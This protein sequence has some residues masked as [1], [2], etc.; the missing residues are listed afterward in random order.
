MR[1]LV[2][3]NEVQNFGSEALFTKLLDDYQKT[4]DASFKSDIRLALPNTTNP[5]LIQQ[6]V[7]NFENAAVIKPQDLRAWYRGLLNNEAG[8]QA[9]WDWI[10]N[11]WQW[12][13][14]TVGG[15]M[16]FATFITVTANIFHTPARLAEF[17]SFFT[18]K[19]QTPGLTREIKM[20]LDLIKGKV[21]L[22]NKERNVVNDTINQVLN[23]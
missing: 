13:E 10:R 17:E 8:Q 5:E 7:N 6:I 2:L 12:L 23:K 15:D 22:I 18:P 16:E 14:D 3:K 4:A 1:G 20:D 19:L 11:D 9:A 21:S